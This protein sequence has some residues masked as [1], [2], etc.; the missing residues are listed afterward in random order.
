MSI[1]DDLT[2]ERG[3]WVDASTLWAEPTEAGPV[4]AGLCCLECGAALAPTGAER[5]RKCA[6]KAAHAEGRAHVVNPGRFGQPR[7][8]G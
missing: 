6:L 1:M 7:R 5:C 2:S 8:T 3:T 4:P